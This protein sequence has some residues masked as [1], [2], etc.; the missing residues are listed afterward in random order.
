MP[1]PSETLTHQFA[2]SFFLASRFL[3]AAK[4]NA[5][6]ALY[7]FCRTVDQLIDEKGSVNEK[8]KKL[9]AWKKELAMTWEKKGHKNPILSAFVFTC[10]THSIPR[11]WGFRLIEGLRVDLVHTRYETFDELYA[12]CF[13]AGSIPGILMNYAMGGN[14]R[15]APYAISLGI[16]MQLT[17]ILRDMKEDLDMGRV[18]LPQAELQEFGYSLNEL[19]NHVLNE[20][21]TRYLQFSISRA[22]TYYMQAEKGIE[23]LPSDVQLSIRLCSIFY[24]RILDEIE[25][26]NYDVFSS[27]AVVSEER[28]QSLIATLHPRVLISHSNF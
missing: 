3:P 28:K 7:A 9:A 21:F 4:R 27:R 2:H 23:L 11:E 14:E 8:E 10:N 15:T 19:E 17:N 16:G 20:N 24:Q 18:Y 5:A 12:Y 26:N 1:S 6:F 13:S 25:R 22:R